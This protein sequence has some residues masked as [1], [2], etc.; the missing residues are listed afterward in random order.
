MDA[1]ISEP[2]TCILQLGDLDTI[3]NTWN[4][5]G[6]PGR[7]FPSH[8]QIVGNGAEKGNCG[9]IRFVG[10]C[11]DHHTGHE[12]IARNWCKDRTCPVCHSTWAIR[13]AGKSIERIRAYEK[14]SEAMD[15][16]QLKIGEAGTLLPPRQSELRISWLN[17]VGV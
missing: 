6:V 10:S 4:Q 9:T 5:R 12:V 15:G 7:H 17:Q 11:T 1:A 13:Q 16:V 3:R 8:L 14:I 2:Y